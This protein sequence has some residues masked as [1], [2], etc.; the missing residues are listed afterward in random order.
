M[1]NYAQAY[2]FSL[3]E[4]RQDNTVPTEVP[5]RRER[6]EPAPKKNISY[7]PKEQLE[8]NRK[9]KPRIHPLKAIATA[10]CF[11]VI[12]G[13]VLSLIYSQVQLTELTDELATQTKELEAAQALEVQLS[14]A[15]TEQLKSSEVEK[16]ARDQLGMDRVTRGQVIYLNLATTDKAE[17]L[18]ET[19]QDFLGE[20]VETVQSWFR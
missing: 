13:T 16:Y 20:L 3:F 12:F 4:E 5:Q 19:K 7:L 2:D 10:L 15:S 17:V 9:A 18:E 14:M 8:K 11:T 6:S 1:V